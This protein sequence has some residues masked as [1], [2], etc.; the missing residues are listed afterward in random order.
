MT[1]E[2]ETK[3]KA[4]VKTSEFWLT[5]VVE[6]IGA[7]MASGAIADGSK[8]AMICGAV[9]SILGVLGYQ[10]QRTKAKTGE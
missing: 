4:G 3:V 7:L 6:A 10:A 9:L 8:T 1:T 2:T 5:L